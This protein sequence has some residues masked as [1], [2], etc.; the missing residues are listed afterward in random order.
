MRHFRGAAIL[1]TLAALFFGCGRASGAPEPPKGAPTASAP[2]PTAPAPESKAAPQTPFDPDDAYNKAAA[3]AAARKF[4]EA[5]QAFEDAARQ[6]P[7]DGA[8][9]AAVAVFADLSASRISEDVVQRMFQAGQHANA[10]KWV[11]AQADIDEAIKLAPKYPRA[12]GL[13][14]TLLL[15]QGKPAEALDAFDAAVR[16]DPEFGSD[17]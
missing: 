1:L 9:T 11:E 15:E 13:R 14:G 2:A 7:K 17:L 8:L 5:R 6:A 12:H 10:D 16:I 4:V 3:L